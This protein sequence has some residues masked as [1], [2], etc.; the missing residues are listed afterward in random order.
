M[1]LP[2]SWKASDEV[3]PK[4]ARAE[5]A[6]GLTVRDDDSGL[7]RRDGSAMA[8]GVSRWGLASDCV[9]ERGR[10]ASRACW[11][12]NSSV[13]RLVEPHVS[14]RAMSGGARPRA[15][16][17]LLERPMVSRDWRALRLRGLRGTLSARGLVARLAM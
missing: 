8:G 16:G 7:H 4:P 13:S 15:D 2:D 6:R 3:T 17:G 1:L 5:V 12:A 10:W 14:E 9:V 11:R